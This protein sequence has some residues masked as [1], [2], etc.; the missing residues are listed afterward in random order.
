MALIKRLKQQATEQEAILPIAEDAEF[1]AI[2]S[3]IQELECLRGEKL[4][5]REKLQDRRRQLRSSSFVDFLTVKFLEGSDAD[6]ASVIEQLQLVND[7]LLALQ[8][9]VEIAKQQQAIVRGRLSSQMREIQFPIYRQLGRRVLA[10]M[11]AL[12]AANDGVMALRDALERGGYAA[13]TFTPV[14]MAPW[15]FWGNIGDPTS[16]WQMHLLDLMER[17]FIDR[18]EF[19]TI[20]EGDLTSFQA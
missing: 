15:P 13:D 4:A 20:A 2:G 3:K 19:E 7:E 11:L 10:A 17:K 8:K 14:G 6:E 12:Q 9:A 16:L 5:W 1:L 18:S